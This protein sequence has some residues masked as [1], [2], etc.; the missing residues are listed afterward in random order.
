MVL[1]VNTDAAV[2]YAAKLEQ[3][4]K[5]ALP[6]AVRRTLNSAAIDVKTNTMLSESDKAFHKRKPTFFN[7]TSRAQMAQG[8]D[9]NSMQSI[10]GF[11]AP[12]N[13]KESGHATQDLEEQE[14]GG[15]IAKRAFIATDGGR[16]TRG[17][18]KD[19]LT[20]RVIKPHIVDS[21]NMKG[22]ETSHMLSHS[23]SPEEAFTRA[24]IKVGFGGGS[25][26]GL[27]I[28]SYRNRSGG[29][30]V[31]QILG[32]KKVGRNMKIKSKE[33]YT[34]KGGRD[35]HIHATHF[36]VKASNDT[37]KKMEGMFII[38]AQKA[39]NI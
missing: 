11:V 32:M 5:I 16:T 23:L 36:M 19:N 25:I 8:L 6:L 10:V 24:A 20:M 14:H 21:L 17:N 3:Q 28:G 34:V 18:V 2:V 1:I 33:I 38:H 22:N 7:A 35:A 4:R 13:I 27:V 39:L 12:A 30:G 26:G 9:I 37:A 31:Y 15:S 29:R